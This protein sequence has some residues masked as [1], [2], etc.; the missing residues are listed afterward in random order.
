MN[1]KEYAIMFSFEDNYWWY[2]SLHEL[3]KYFVDFKSKKNLEKKIFDAG[4]GTGKMLEILNNYIFTEGIDFSEEAILF[5]KKRNLDNVRQDNLNTWKEKKDFYN[6]IISA[7]V[8]CSIGIKDEIDIL[9]KFYNSLQEGGQ[10]I[11]NLPALNILSRNHDK[12]VF[13]RKRY[14][15]KELESELKKIG[16]KINLITYRHSG[17]YFIILIKKIFEGFSK[18]KTTKSDLTEIPN[19]LNR[20]LLFF[21]RIEN[22]FIKKGLY[23]PLGSSLFVVAEKN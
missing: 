7:D 6:F 5:C 11:L 1:E 22:Y 23:I 17:L 18:E 21:S 19:L 16:F 20:I 15:K 12:A 9:N 13:V 3:I 10:L 2:I 14:N 4:C 8:I